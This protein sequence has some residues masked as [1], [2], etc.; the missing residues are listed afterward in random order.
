MGSKLGKV[1]RL[2]LVKTVVHP[3]LMLLVAWS[4]GLRGL[5]LSVMV[6]VAA[7]PMGANGFLFSQRYQKEED[8][9]T[10]AV[11]VSTLMATVG[12]SLALAWLPSV[13]S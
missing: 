2:S 12:I 11:A 1:I 3:L 10:A 8:T 7:L 5:P 6:V 9:V 13:A 4:C